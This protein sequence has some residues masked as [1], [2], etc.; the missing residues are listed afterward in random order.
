MKVSVIIP[1][2][3]AEKYLAVC[4]ESILIQTF[5]D[6]EVIVVDDCS[7]DSSPVIA[8]SYLERFDGRL[9]ILTLKENT[10]SGAV[11]RNVGLEFSQGKYVFFMDSDDL[12]ID[13]ALETLYDFA[14]EYQAEVVYMDCGFVCDSEPIIPKTLVEAAWDLNNFVKEPKLETHD[15]SV[16][17]KKFLSRQYKWPPWGKFLRRDFLINNVIKFPQMQISEDGTWT[18]E[19]V[20]LSKKFLYVPSPLY[21]QRRNS[22]SMTRLLRSPEQEII[23]RTSPLINGMEHLEKFMSRQ[24]FFKR[25][26]DLRLQILMFFAQV[27]F[28]EMK[29]VLNRLKPVE[30]YEIFLNEF[31]KAGSTQ[32]AL[33]SYLLVMNNIY[34]NELS[35]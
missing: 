23:F 13:T 34:Q 22:S 35:K 8:E 4:L 10:G 30:V 27:Q 32:P 12:I 25:N 21:V 1:V 31:L 20:C 18:L 5:Q 26:P 16:R 6:Y 9:K 24:N 14:E 29:K 7:T 33:I 28:D 17:I 11:P 15:L 3:N 19:L 2:Y